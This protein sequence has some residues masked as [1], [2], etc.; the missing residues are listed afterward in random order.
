MLSCKNPRKT[1]MAEKNKMQ[2]NVFRS[3][4]SEA[5]KATVNQI[6]KAGKKLSKANCVFSGV[7]ESGSQGRGASSIVKPLTIFSRPGKILQ[8]VEGSGIREII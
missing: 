3:S 2:L 8:I 7:N 6:A 5:D 4:F 1:E